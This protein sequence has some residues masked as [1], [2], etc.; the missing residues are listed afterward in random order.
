MVNNASIRFLSSPKDYGVYV[1]FLVQM[2]YLF[3][4]KNMG[5]T[6]R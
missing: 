6:K 3:A 2:I 5:F 1:C 4:R